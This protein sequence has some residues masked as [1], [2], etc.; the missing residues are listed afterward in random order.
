M[1]TIAPV[2]TKN[3]TPQELEN[4]CKAFQ[5]WSKT[6]G[7]DVVASGRRT[8]WTNESLKCMAG[9]LNLKRDMNKADLIY[10]IIAKMENKDILQNRMTDKFKKEK[11]T[12]IRII[13]I[14]MQNEDGWARS[15]LL[16][17]RFTLQMRLT[18]PNRPISE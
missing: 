18:G 16:A 9:H 1:A 10:A 8:G 11:H 12:V 7:V 3:S 15:D 17:N 5:A 2:L 6:E 4:A 14:L 13:N